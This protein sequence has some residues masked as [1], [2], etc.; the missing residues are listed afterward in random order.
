MTEDEAVEV[1]ERLGYR[2]TS[3]LFRL[4]KNKLQ[5]TPTDFRNQHTGEMN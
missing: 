2:N 1:A 4:F 5:I 3:S